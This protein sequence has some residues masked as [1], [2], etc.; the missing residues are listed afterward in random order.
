[1]IVVIVTIIMTG[2]AMAGLTPGVYNVTGEWKEFLTNGQGGQAGNHIEAHDTVWRMTADLVPPPNPAAA[3]WTWLTK[4]DNGYLEL[5]LG[6][7]WNE[8][9]SA[10]GFD[11]WV[12]STGYDTTQGTL[13]WKMSGSGVL[14]TG[15][16]FIICATFGTPSNP[17]TPTISST[18]GG[19]LMIGEL[20]SAKVMIGPNA[21][22]APGALLLGGIGAGFVGWLRRRRTL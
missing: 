21:I 15:D 18:T 20:T 10:S 16:D 1:L 19:A 9:A 5:D 12:W 3:P 11:L 22:P 14:N 6:G 7:P 2:Q 17:S 13:A 4:Y 8:A